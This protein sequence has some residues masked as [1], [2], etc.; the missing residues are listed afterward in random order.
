MS[1]MAIYGTVS[2]FLLRTM[3]MQ[4]C[5]REN[6]LEIVLPVGADDVDIDSSS[7]GIVCF[8]HFLYILFV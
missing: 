6:D 5:C 8:D 3:C 2:F 7:I 4:L 1:Y